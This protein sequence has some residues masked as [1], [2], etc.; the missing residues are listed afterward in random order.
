MNFQSCDCLMEVAGQFDISSPQYENL[1]SLGSLT[2]NP[3][4]IIYRYELSKIL[5]ELAIYG[6]NYKEFIWK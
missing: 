6:A 3:F 4:Y 2:P 5:R 1:F